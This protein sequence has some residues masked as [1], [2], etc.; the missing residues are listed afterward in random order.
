MGLRLL[1]HYFDRNEALIVSALLDES[2]IANFV[3]GVFHTAV[4]PWNEFTLGGYR[5][6][7]REEDM[8][9]AV[10]EVCD[11]RAQRVLEGGKL[12]THHHLAFPLAGI[13]TFLFGGWIFF[14]PYRSHSWVDASE[15][16]ADEPR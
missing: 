14:M 2:G 15:E 6:M 16:D 13:L 8:T 3:H 5:V 12:V 11:A 7:V 10:Q 1:A 4:Q 9:A